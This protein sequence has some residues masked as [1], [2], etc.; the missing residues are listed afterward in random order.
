[1]MSR[2]HLITRIL[3]AGLL[4]IA[5]MG[6]S[7]ASAEG[8]TIAI[9]Y[10]GHITGIDD[11]FVGV[12]IDGDNNATVYICDGQPDKGT[13]SIAQ[14][15]VGTINN[16]LIDVTAANG[17]RVE[18][19]VTP[20]NANGKFTFADGTVK[21]FALDL[22]PASAGLFRSEFAFGDKKLV[23]GWIVLPDGSVRGAVFD[24]ETEELVP[25]SFVE[26]NKVPDT[27]LG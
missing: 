24:T 22:F 27:P 9:T 15:F 16:G 25:A 12:A 13:V 17:N 14:W 26:F 5:V 21:E 20:A 11:E 2:S 10:G 7:I 1:M 18:V 4:L 8:S 23:G 3:S 6:V 19:T